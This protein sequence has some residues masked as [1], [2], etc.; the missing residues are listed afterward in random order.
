MLAPSLSFAA[1]KVTYY[2]TDQ[3]QTPLAMADASGQVLALFDYSPYGRAAL[4]GASDG[5]G[6]DG[7]VADTDQG[8]DYMQARYYDPQAGQFLS[9]DPVGPSAGD[10]FKFNRYSFADGNPVV[11]GDPTG[12][13]PSTGNDMNICGGP[14]P[15]EVNT[16]GSTGNVV[17]PASNEPTPPEQDAHDEFIAM[18][19]IN[20]FD[21]GNEAHALLQILATSNPGYFAEQWSDGAFTWFGG[22]P[23]IGNRITKELWEVKSVRSSGFAEK[24]LDKYIFFSRHTYKKGGLPSFFGRSS[25]IALNGVYA[26]YQY[27]FVRPGVINYTFKLNDEYEYKTIGRRVPL[28]PPISISEFFEDFI[29]DPVPVP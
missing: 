12:M 11:N 20:Q 26:N 10:I 3:Q 2:Y 9:V 28:A 4:G 17:S 16:G 6:Y 27:T 7:H 13:D 15:C 14:V 22:R 1:E 19:N 24:Q 29:R 25:T 23:D 5:I 8:L 21:V 18:I